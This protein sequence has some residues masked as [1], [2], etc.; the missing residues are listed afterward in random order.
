MAAQSTIYFSG[1]KA[2]MRSIHRT[3]TATMQ[4]HQRAELVALANAGKRVADGYAF[5]REGDDFAHLV[6]DDATT[7]QVDEAHPQI[8]H[9]LRQEMDNVAVEEA[10]IGAVSNPAPYIRRTFPPFD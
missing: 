10:I 4:R 1:D 3:R 7:A 6:S 2:W 9:A 5:I 8:G